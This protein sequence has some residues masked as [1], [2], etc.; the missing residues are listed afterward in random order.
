MNH[1]FVNVYQPPIPGIKYACPCCSFMTL[2]ER[3]GSDIC[4]VCF[5]EDDGQDSHDAD[6][7]RGGPNGTLSLSIARQNFAAFGACEEKFLLNVR[8]TL[9]NEVAGSG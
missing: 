3:A 6:E 5:W 9:P 7:I 2:D 4:P 8:N 1:P